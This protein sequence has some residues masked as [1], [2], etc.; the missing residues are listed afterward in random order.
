M[1]KIYNKLFGNKMQGQRESEQLKADLFLPWVFQGILLTTLLAYIVAC[2]AFGDQIQNTLPDDQRILIRTILY[3][4]AIIT[5]PMTNLIRHIQLRL[6]QTMPFSG[7]KPQAVAKRRYL[8]TTIVSMLLIESIGVFGFVMFVLGDNFNTLFIF[9][10]LSA[11]GFFLYRPKL[12][13]Y[14]SIVDALTQAKDN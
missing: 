14:I 3:V 12:T 6:N 11:L 4:A 1:I 13:E 2:F 5:F 7:I 9:S 10:G 8:V